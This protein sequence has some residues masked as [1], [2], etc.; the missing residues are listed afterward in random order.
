MRIAYL[1]FLSANLTVL[2]QDLVQPRLIKKL[3]NPRFRQD[4]EI[5]LIVYAP[6]SRRLATAGDGSLIVWSEI[7]DRLNEFSLAPE[8]TPVDI[9]FHSDGRQLLVA[10][11]DAKS[12]Y[13]IQ[14]DLL[15]KSKVRESRLFDKPVNAQF[16]TN[17]RTV[18]VYDRVLDPQRKDSHQP[19]IWLFSTESAMALWSRPQLLALAAEVR[20]D[21]NRI[22]LLNAGGRFLEVDVATNRVESQMDLKITHCLAAKYSFGTQKLVICQKLEGNSGV[23]E[24]YDIKNRSRSWRRIDR[25]ILQFHLSRDEQLLLGEDRDCKTISISQSDGEFLKLLAGP[26]ASLSPDGSR[27]AIGR[28]G[29]FITQFSTASGELLASPSPPGKAIGHRVSADGRRIQAWSDGWYEWDMTTGIQSAIGP[30]LKSSFNHE[31]TSDLGYVLESQSNREW[32]THSVRSTRTGDLALVVRSLP[33]CRAALVGKNY[34]SIADP[35][36]TTLHQISSGGR[37]FAL[38]MINSLDRFVSSGSYFATSDEKAITLIDA[39]ASQPELRATVVMERAGVAIPLG[40]ST[41]GQ[42][43]ALLTSVQVTQPFAVTHRKLMV[44]FSTKTTWCPPDSFC[45][46][47][48]FSYDNRSIMCGYVEEYFVTVTRQPRFEI[49]GPARRSV[50]VQILRDTGFCGSRRY[51]VEIW[52][53]LGKSNPWKA[54]SPD[55]LW[56]R[57]A[58]LDAKQAYVAICHLRHHPDE[59]SWFLKHRVVVGKAPSKEWIAERVGELDSN[60]FRARE[61]AHKQLAEVAHLISP[62]LQTAL[63]NAGPEGRDRLQRL[64]PTPDALFCRKLREVRACEVAEGLATPAAIQL[65]RQWSAAGQTTTLGSEA[66]ESLKRLDNR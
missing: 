50:E 23:I 30:R 2:A 17:G 48:S 41:N 42:T 46:S 65:L 52:S 49:S 1:I 10:T 27:L 57:L 9:C 66:L 22:A 13:L 33:N 24:Q 15:T 29:P 28:F 47:C 26:C 12:L 37:T 34:L 7:G 21:G 63:T 20:S 54:I 6:D 25:A 61:A 32:I 56:D 5:S 53:I 31:V 38:P 8:R 55:E 19:G 4:E 45:Y 64:I 44:D 14:F 43:A 60:K 40:L 36:G 39:G 58:D 59:A 35:F 51:P 16:S 11:K 18:L 3:G 62:E